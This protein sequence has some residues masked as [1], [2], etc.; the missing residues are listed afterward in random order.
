MSGK[1]EGMGE[2]QNVYEKKFEVTNEVRCKQLRRGVVSF[3]KF[4]IIQRILFCLKI[5]SN[6]IASGILL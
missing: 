3:F 2:S 5:I 4:D 6:K 1:V